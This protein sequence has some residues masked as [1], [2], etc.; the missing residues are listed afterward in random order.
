MASQPDDI[1]VHYDAQAAFWGATDSQWQ[2]TV[3]SYDL[4]CT[5]GYGR[6][7]LDAICDLLDRTEK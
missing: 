5:V 7:P 2:A 1:E 4:G 6:T 3:G